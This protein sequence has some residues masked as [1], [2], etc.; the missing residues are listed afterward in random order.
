MQVDQ[1]SLGAVPGRISHSVV[2]LH[3]SRRN[4]IKTLHTLSC[5]T[6]QCEHTHK[7]TMPVHS[8]HIYFTFETDTKAIMNVNTYNTVFIHTIVAMHLYIE[9][10]SPP[11][12][13]VRF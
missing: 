10:D 8:F 1:I 7:D 2:G 4:L 3:N 11:S 6:C 12:L 13:S 5:S 9:H